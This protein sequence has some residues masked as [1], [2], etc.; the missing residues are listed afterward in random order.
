[1][2]SKIGSVGSGN[3]SFGVNLNANMG[4]SGAFGSSSKIPA[5]E[6][7]PIPVTPQPGGG[8]GSKIET[9]SSF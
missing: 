7:T 5:D 4:L 8:G 6:A 2:D 9:K 1:M 3:P